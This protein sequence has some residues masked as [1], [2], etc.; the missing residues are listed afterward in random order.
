MK[1]FIKICGITSINDACA[2]VSSGADAIGLM[3]Y[4][5]SPRSIS[6]EKAVEISKAISKKVLPIMVFANQTKDHVST[7]LD[8][9]PEAIPQ[10]HGSE[11]S[12]FCS[13]FKR[14]FIKAIQVTKKTNFDQ[15]SKDFSKAKMLLFDTKDKNLLGGTGK[16]F[17]W[18]LITKELKK[19]FILAGGLNSG[20][21]ES[22]LT[23]VS[24]SGI[25]VS[26]GV[27]SSLGK[28]DPDKIRKFVNKVRGFDG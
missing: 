13:S 12:Q 14:D 16:T 22:A 10:F 28:K 2:A 5:K 1:I 6:L 17:H 7:C 11:D 18:G 19:P 8:A 4:K 9:V 3:M 25:D 23:E 21:I 15:I 24:C 26:S 20:N 27:E